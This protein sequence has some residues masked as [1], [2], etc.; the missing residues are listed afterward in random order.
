[1]VMKVKLLYTDES[2]IML[3]QKDPEVISKNLHQKG[4]HTAIIVGGFI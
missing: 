4:S 1:M 3:S 2:A